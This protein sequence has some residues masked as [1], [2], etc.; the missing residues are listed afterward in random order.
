VS[1]KSVVN[2][3]LAWSVRYRIPVWLCPER[4][5][6]ETLTFRLLQHFWNWREKQHKEER[7]DGR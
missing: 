6:A 1:P 3:L 5:S 4:K 2:S 7:R